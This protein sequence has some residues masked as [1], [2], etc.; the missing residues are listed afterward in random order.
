MGKTGNYVRFHFLGS[1]INVD[2]DCSHEIKRHLLLGRKA[3]TNIKKPE[4]SLCQQ[5]CVKSKLWFFQYHVWMWELDH[6]ESWVPEN[7]CFSTVVLE[8][9]LESP[10]GYKEIKPVS[11]KGNQSVLNSPWKDWCW[12]WSSNTLAT[13]CEELTY[14][15]RPWSWQRL[16]ARGEGGDRG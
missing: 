15:K 16:R 8:K 12:S 2:C 7:W 9:T 10:V 3:M 1:K 6:K 14:W 11:P 5:R 4:T 13:L